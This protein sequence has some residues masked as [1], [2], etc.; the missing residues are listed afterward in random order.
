MWLKGF[1]VEA[2]LSCFTLKSSFT[3]S[4]FH[5]DMQI[6]KISTI[7]LEFAELP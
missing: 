1:I 3:I 6:Y 4:A 2:Q 7:Y 5:F